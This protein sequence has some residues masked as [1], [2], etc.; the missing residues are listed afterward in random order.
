MVAAP[1][2][3]TGVHVEDLLSAT[4]MLVTVE[5]MLLEVVVVVEEDLGREVDQLSGETLKDH[6]PTPA[7][8]SA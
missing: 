4:H 2:E 7:R 8:S 5:V 6:K 3:Q 1:I